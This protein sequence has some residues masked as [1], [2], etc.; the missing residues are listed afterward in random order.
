MYIREKHANSVYTFLDFWVLTH[1]NL[2]LSLV[3]QGISMWK[4]SEFFPWDW[5]LTQSD[6]H[7]HLSTEYAPE[8]Q[9]DMYI[10]ATFW[11]AECS[12]HIPV[13]TP[14]SL[15]SKWALSGYES[16]CLSIEVK[17]IGSSRVWFICPVSLHSPHREPWVTNSDVDICILPYESHSQSVIS[18]AYH[19]RAW[20]F[21]TKEG[22]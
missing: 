19:T 6:K 1:V 5:I 10:S 22:R 9:R 2:K 17:K 7:V 4:T 12:H 15:T 21:K 8:P 16:F 11:G 14:T 20:D 3:F 13:V 18:Q